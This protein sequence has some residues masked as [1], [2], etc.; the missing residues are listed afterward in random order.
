[1]QCDFSKIPRHLKYTNAPE[2]N[3]IDLVR[4][5]LRKNLILHKEFDSFIESPAGQAQFRGVMDMSNPNQVEGN[6]AIDGEPKNVYGFL[7]EKGFHK[8]QKRKRGDPVEV[9]PRLT[10]NTKNKRT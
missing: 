8:P 6:P 9:I 3:N 10:M 7:I 2:D 4:H 1:M 5:R